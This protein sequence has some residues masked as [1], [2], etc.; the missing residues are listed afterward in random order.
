M[1]RRLLRSRS[2]RVI[3]GSRPPRDIRVIRGIQSDAGTRLIRE[4]ADERGVHEG[5]TCGIQLGDENVRASVIRCA[6]RAGRR[7][8]QRRI[9]I[10]GDI[11]VARCI[12]RNG[13]R[14]IGACAAEKCRIQKRR[15]GG[16][17]FCDE[18][19]PG[20]VRRRVECA[21]CNRKVDRRRDARDVHVATAV[22]RDAVSLVT[23]GAAEKCR[24]EQRGTCG[25]ELQHKHVRKTVDGPVVRARRGRKIGRVGFADDVRIAVRIDRDA[26]RDLACCSAA[27]VRRVH[28]AGTVRIELRNHAV[29]R[30]IESHVIGAWRRRKNRV[31][32]AGHVRA[33]RGV[34]SDPKALILPRSAEE[35]RIAERWIDHQRIR[36][37]VL[38]DDETVAR[39]ASQLVTGGYVDPPTGDLLIADWLRILEHPERGIEQELPV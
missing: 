10:A 39:A 15:A 20:A 38:A 7:G 37:V 30:P 18:R 25:I 19:I 9:G 24:K 2:H 36:V 29:L 8:E 26:R 11:R 12:D 6:E 1:Q 28:E 16:I 5:R 17:Q 3:R 34:H 22:D 31:R 13:P 35:G 14:E 21:R 27:D 23:V 32:A 4:T 33:A